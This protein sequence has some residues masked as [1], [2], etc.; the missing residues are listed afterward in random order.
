[1]IV[2]QLPMK[3]SSYVCRLSSNACTIIPDP[4]LIANCQQCDLHPPYESYQSIFWSADIY[5]E[6]SSDQ[7][8]EFTDAFCP[9]YDRCKMTER[10][11]TQQ[12]AFLGMPQRSCAC[13]LT[14]IEIH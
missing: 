7:P 3:L 1:M 6:Q 5:L 14:A 12:P 8:V 11:M 4:C 13:I 9:L 2:T 10:M